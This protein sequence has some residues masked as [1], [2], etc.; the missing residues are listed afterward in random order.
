MRLTEEDLHERSGRRPRRAWADSQRVSEA[1]ASQ[2]A[3]EGEGETEL[4]LGTAT[5]GRSR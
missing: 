1:A 3:G 5:L 4:D 2:E